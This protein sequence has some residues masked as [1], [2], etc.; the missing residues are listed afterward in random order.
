MPVISVRVSTPDHEALRAEADRLG[1][2]VADIIR[3]GIKY[4]TEVVPIAEALA[5]IERKVDAIER[6]IEL[7]GDAA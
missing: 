7:V 2:T 5:R 3:S 1:S 6:L 4:R